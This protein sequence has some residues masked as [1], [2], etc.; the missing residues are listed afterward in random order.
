MLNK[1]DLTRL[2]TA[3]LQ[4]VFSKGV[5]SYTPIYPALT[6]EVESVGASEIYGRLGANPSLR[7]WRDERMP[8]KLLENGFTVVN[9][10]WEATISVSRNAI[11]DDRYGQIKIQVQA[12]GFAGA[13]GYDQAYATVVEAGTAALCYDG[14]YFFD[15]DHA[16]GESGTQANYATGTALSVANAKTVITAMQ[17]FK[18]DRGINAGINPTHIMVPPALR[19]TANEIFDPKG[20]GDTNANTSLKGVLQIIVNPFLTLATTWYVMDLSQPVKPIIY[21]NRQPLEFSNTETGD[22]AFSR[23]EIQYGVDARFAFAYGDWRTAYRAIA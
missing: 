15:T 4:T 7:E 3:G 10:D 23:K 12:L 16:E 2:M 6:T 22:A 21:Q 13:K 1:G 18:D 19:F 14:Q 9:K 11:K 17:N 8:K 5:S 20:T